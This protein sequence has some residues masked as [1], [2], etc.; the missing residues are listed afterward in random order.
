MFRLTELNVTEHA[1]RRPSSART[2]PRTSYS[3]IFGIHAKYPQIINIA[4]PH[5]P[6]ITR[7]LAFMLLLLKRII[8]P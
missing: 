3:R 1:A 5:K 2:T 4:E 7:F 6:T 8:S